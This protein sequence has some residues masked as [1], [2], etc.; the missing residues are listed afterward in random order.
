MKTVFTGTEQRENSII[1]TGVV[2][3]VSPAASTIRLP[4]SYLVSVLQ[5]N[6]AI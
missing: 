6:T 4:L 2:V 1:C 3:L 5:A